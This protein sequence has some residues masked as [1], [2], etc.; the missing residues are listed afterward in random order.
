MAPT[1]APGA[2]RAG[3]APEQ[4]VTDASHRFRYLLGDRTAPPLSELTAW[5]AALGEPFEP[6]EDGAVRLRALPVVLHRAPGSLEAEILLTPSVP[7]SRLLALIYDLALQAGAEVALLADDPDHPHAATERATA[8][9][10]FADEQDRLRI[11]RAI[12]RAEARTDDLLRGLWDILV[13][14][15]RGRDLRWHPT[16]A[17]I[18]EVDASDLDSREDPTLSEEE[19]T[20]PL[21]VVRAVE[22]GTHI[23]AWRWLTEAWPSVTDP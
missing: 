12:G 23:L 7:L 6:P 15:G 9:L 13:A 4:A 21:L 8:W 14:L 18:V 5:L 3:R 20:D 19:A 2:S 1:R 22:P 11:G 17:R 16:R 10:R